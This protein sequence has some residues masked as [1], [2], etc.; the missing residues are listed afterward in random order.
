[1][2]SASIV[3]SSEPDFSAVDY[4]GKTGLPNLE[5]AERRYVLESDHAGS[6]VDDM[7]VYCN[8]CN[9]CIALSAGKRGGTPPG[10]LTNWIRHRQICP[11]LQRK[12]LRVSELQRIR[13]CWVTS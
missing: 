13:T 3:D 9:K 5:A 8:G 7:T 12:G 4:L 2:I 6:M 11:E 10:S 1:M